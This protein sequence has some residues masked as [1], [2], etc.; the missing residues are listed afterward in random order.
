[1]LQGTNMGTKPV[2]SRQT[3]ARLSPHVHQKLRSRHWTHAPSCP[4]TALY[5]LLCCCAFQPCH[6]FS[7][8]LKST[9][10]IFAILER[11]LVQA[12]KVNYALMGLQ[13]YSSYLL[14]GTTAAIEIWENLSIARSAQTTKTIYEI[15]SVAISEQTH[16]QHTP[17]SSILMG[18][19]FSEPQN[20]HFVNDNY[21]CIVESSTLCSFCITTTNVA[22]PFRLQ[23]FS[24]RKT[25]KIWLKGVIRIEGVYVISVAINGWAIFVISKGFLFNEMKWTATKTFSEI[26][27]NTKQHS[28]KNQLTSAGTVQKIISAVSYFHDRAIISGFPNCSEYQQIFQST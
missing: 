16:R 20:S 4:A 9:S 17:L 26:I 2:G 27:V 14:D 28:C 5:E 13:F 25:I 10:R 22:G 18:K 19:F 21:R 8:A 7:I 3:A 24:S 1:M 6:I 12:W 11:L 23:P 15:F